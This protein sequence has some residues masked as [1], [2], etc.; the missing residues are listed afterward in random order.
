MKSNNHL[1]KEVESWWTRKSHKQR[2]R[3]AEKHLGIVTPVQVGNLTVIRLFK[4]S[5][6][7]KLF[8]ITHP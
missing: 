2:Y 3:L 1:T 7:N 4:N 6:I 5:T 8:K